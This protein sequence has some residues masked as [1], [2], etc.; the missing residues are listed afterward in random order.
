MNAI[1]GQIRLHRWQLDERR[2]QLADLDQLALKLRREAERLCQEKARPGDN[3]RQRIG[4]SL[5]S[6]E[7]QRALAREA[8]AATY[9]EMKRYEVAAANAH[10]LMQPQRRVERVRPEAPRPALN[11]RRARRS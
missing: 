4:A 6:V 5:A 7:Q 2:R 1:D 9:Q 11:A 8:L 3:R 10:R